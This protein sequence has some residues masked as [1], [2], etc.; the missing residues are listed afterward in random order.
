MSSNTSPSF[1]KFCKSPFFL[2]FDPKSSLSTE[3][4]VRDPCIAANALNATADSAES[5]VLEWE[6]SS[7]VMRLRTLKPFCAVASVGTSSNESEGILMA[8]S[9]S[10]LRPEEMLSPMWPSTLS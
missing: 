2:I 9:L 3:E 4:G 7:A 6:R 10:S 8:S 5:W 1:H